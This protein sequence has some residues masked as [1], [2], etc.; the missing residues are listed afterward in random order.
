MKAVRQ[1]RTGRVWDISKTHQFWGN[2]GLSPCSPSAGTG[3]AEPKVPDA[4]HGTLAPWPQAKSPSPES[5]ERLPNPGFWILWETIL[6]TKLLVF[7][8]DEKEKEEEPEE[9]K[10]DEE[11]E[12][13]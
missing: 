5:E 8:E 2:A 6:R 4:V 1:S 10:D 7:A 3:R 12:D 13:S 11:E 9:A